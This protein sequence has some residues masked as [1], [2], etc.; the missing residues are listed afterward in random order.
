MLGYIPF[1]VVEKNILNLNE[2][3]LGKFVYSRMFIPRVNPM[4]KILLLS[5]CLATAF[6]F[7]SV[8]AHAATNTFTGNGNWY[9]PNN[10]AGNALPSSTDDVDLLPG[11]GNGAAAAAY[12]DNGSVTVNSV[13]INPTNGLAGSAGY[14]VGAGALNVTGALTVGGTGTTTTFLQFN[15]NG[16]LNAGSIDFSGSGGASQ[17]QFLTLGAGGSLT[18]GG[19]TGTITHSGTSTL[20]IIA[21]GAT[22]ATINANINSPNSTY[23]HA[24]DQ[25]TGAITIGS[26]NSWNVFVTQVSVNAQNTDTG[27]LNINGGSLTTQ[28]VYLNNGAQGGNSVVNLNAGGT[29]KA[30]DIRR[31]Q[32]GASQ[33]FNWNDGTIANWVANAPQIL[34]SNL[35]SGTPLVL[36]LAGTGTHTFEV[37]GATGT[38][39]VSSSAMLVD[40]VGENGTLT[41]T[42]AGTLD[43]QSV[44]TYTGGTTISAGQLT[45]STAGALSTATA[46]DL[47][48]A[49]ARFDIGSM[50]AAGSTNGSLAGVAGSVVNLGAKN[51]NVGGNNA[52]TT[53]AGIMTNTGSLTKSGAGTLTLSGANTYLGD[54]TI[55][56]GVLALHGNSRSAQITVSAT[57]VLDLRAAATATTTGS[58]SFAPGSSVSV[59]GTPSGQAVTLITADGGISGTP[60]LVPVPGYALVVNPNSLVLQASGSTFS[61]WLGTN[62]P[63]PQLLMNYALGGAEPSSNPV[64]P[65]LTVE[66]NILTLTAT[67]R[68]DDSSL[69][70]YGQWT[71]DLSG[72]TDRWEDHTVELSPPNL[73]FSQGVETDKPRKFMRLKVTR[74]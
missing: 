53:F 2:H 64:L 40:K 73:L 60:S 31:V 33:T 39:T 55:S 44:S 59:S 61:G 63:T 21:R 62:E 54:T 68:S 9:D 47:A 1:M 69:R 65:V 56:A 74:Q 34:Q 12:V 30:F 7:L 27:T 15:G 43:I 4:K 6:I 18:V 35:G 38:T 3:L 66:G 24:G 17:N 10:W 52:S 32:A 20:Y 11:L 50:T 67:G 41:K 58:V 16:A 71:T 8:S 23:L 49:T 46:L 36:S 28:A 19:G 14:I 70:F 57:A 5:M 51:L 13:T 45:L 22:P 29:I 37:T 42:G 26:G 48:G 72:A 25:T